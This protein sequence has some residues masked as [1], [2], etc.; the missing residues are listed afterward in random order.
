MGARIALDAM[1]GDFYAIPNLQGAFRAVKKSIEQKRD[2]KVYL[3]APTDDLNR[4]LNEICKNQHIPTENKIDLALFNEFVRTGR[5]ELVNCSQ[6]VEMTDSPGTVIR[7][8]K[9]SS[10]G[11]AYALIKE[12][13]ADAVVSAGNSGAVMAFG[14]SVL[15]RLPSVRRP[16]ILCN[17]PHRS[18]FTAILDAG[19]NVDCT[20]EHLLQF[21][22]MGQ[23]YAQTVYGKSRPKVALMNIG[24]EEG[25][26]NELV[27][28][29]SILIKEKLGEDYAGFVEGR[30]V[31]SGKVDVIVCDGFVGNVL[32]KTAEGV[33]K[34][35]KETLKEELSK[36]P[37]SMLGAWLAK[38]GFAGLKSKMDYREYGGAPLIGLDGLGFVSHGS[39]DGKAMMNAILSAARAVD[40]GLMPKLRE[41]FQ[42]NEAA[43]STGAST[44]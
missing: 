21:A 8:K 24:E 20:S 36:S 25:K 3:V 39:S 19:A 40:Q 34:L 7:Q 43:S 17:F 37:I 38:S 10:L 31:F 18:G 32:L 27:K 23:I 4:Q 12:G 41:A 14:I 13:R 29:S 28:L 44:S 30:D 15:G 26:G 33:A 35:V 5:L 11:R 16:A 9:D 22:I 42:A 2:L 1:G 6:I